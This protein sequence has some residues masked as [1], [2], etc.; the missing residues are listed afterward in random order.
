V[1]ARPTPTARTST[2]ATV[3]AN[4]AD[5][6]QV[7]TGRFFTCA[8]DKAGVAWC[9]GFNDFGQFGNGTKAN[10]GELVKVVGLPGP[11]LSVHAGFQHACAHLASG[12]VACWGRN[13]VGQ[14][15]SGNSFD[16]CTP[17][18]A[19]SLSGVTQLSAGYSHSCAL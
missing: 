8:V 15:G 4:I 14:L 17:V 13:T 11:A 19:V 16:S 1:L 2:T 12:T 5:A 7:S 18:A 10:A 9:W 6:T 3:K